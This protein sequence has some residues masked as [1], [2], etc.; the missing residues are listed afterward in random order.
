MY[1][2]LAGLKLSSDL[3]RIDGVSL[4]ALVRG[5]AW[6]SLDVSNNSDASALMN[7]SICMLLGVAK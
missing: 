7:V 6:I 5:L 1:L 3:S 4:D 2:F